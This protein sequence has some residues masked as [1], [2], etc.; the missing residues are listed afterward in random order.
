M[1]EELYTRDAN[2]G[3]DALDAGAGASKVVCR[4]LKSVTEMSKAKSETDKEKEDNYGRKLH[5]RNA[6][7]GSETA[8]QTEKNLMQKEFIKTAY[9]RR[10]AENANIAGNFMRKFTDKAEDLMGRF[11]E[12][13]IENV[14]DHPMVILGAIAVLIVILVPCG[15][16]TSCSVMIAGTQ[17]ILIDTSFTAQDD[18]I[19]AV[20]K[21]YIGL[22]EDLQHTIDNIKKNHPGYDEYNFRIDGIFHNPFELAALLTVLYEDYTEPEVRSMLQTIFDDQY[23]LD[24][25]EMVEVRSRT[26]TRTGWHWVSTGVKKGVATGYWDSY[27]YD[28]E[29]EYNYYIL[30]TTLAND[31][32]QAAVNALGLTDEQLERYQILLKT[33]GN[34]PNIFD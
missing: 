26:E 24:I 17:N 32:I 14:A 2:T 31:G 19:V 5:G 4:K 9:E 20:E 21:D 7:T 23:T 18:Q 30:N 13:I 34:K 15:A 25:K 16:M 1:D 3:I 6:G 29:V 11:G 8:N 22:E 28:V 27:Q 33:Q 10:A 12:W